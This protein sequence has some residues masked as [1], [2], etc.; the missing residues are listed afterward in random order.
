MKR[1]PQEERVGKRERWKSWEEMGRLVPGPVC[2]VKRFGCSGG[3][4]W[5]LAENIG[6]T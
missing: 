5:S 2:G 3:L 4:L 1:A 6:S